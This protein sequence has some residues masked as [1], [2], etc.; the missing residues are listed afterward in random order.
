MMKVLVPIFTF[1][2]IFSTSFTLQAVTYSRL[3]DG[4]WS[5]LNL[6]RDNSGGSFN[7]STDLPSDEDTVM[8]NSERV[9][10]L[11]M[12]TSI[13][14]LRLVNN[15]GGGRVN[16]DKPYSLRVED[17]NVG[18]AKNSAS[19]YL[20]ITQGG[21]D[22]NGSMTVFS[23]GRVTIDGGVLGNLFAGASR[24][25]LGAGTIE[26]KSGRLSMLGEK[27]KDKVIFD[28][29]LTIVS[30]GVL[31]GSQTLVGQKS[32]AEF[33]VKGD[34]AKIYLA[35]LCQQKKIA[36]SGTFRFVLN[37]VGVSTIEVATSL[38]LAAAK[39]IV[40]GS[41]YKGGGQVLTLFKAGDF[42]TLLRPENIKVTGLGEPGVGWELIQDEGANVVQLKIHRN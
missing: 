1:V 16:L 40:D 23:N 32:K 41:N 20:S 28:N 33:C 2:S 29:A 27:P 39:L 14:R 15:K 7:S 38:R 31:Q 5:D 9:V 35:S 13:R 4:D 6:W 26:L 8:V 34:V 17:T 24:T 22:M 37:E 25:F 12:D 19:G 18:D 3:T 11:D 10:S 36:P 30:G 21:F 42:V